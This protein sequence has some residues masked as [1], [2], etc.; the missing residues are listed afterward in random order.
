M[1]ISPFLVFTSP[2]SPCDLPFGCLTSRL[3]CSDFHSSFLPFTCSWHPRDVSFSLETSSNCNPCSNQDFQPLFFM[4]GLGLS[5]LAFLVPACALPAPPFCQD[6]QFRVAEGRSPRFVAAPT[7]I[8]ILPE[9]LGGK[10]QLSALVALFKC[11]LHL[12]TSINLRVRVCMCMHV[13]V[14]VSL[15][16]LISRTTHKLAPAA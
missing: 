3:P 13:H 7:H 8:S 12:L 5:S 14:Y 10:L 16:C 9:G 11:F 4:G 6:P 2:A 1:Q 15:S